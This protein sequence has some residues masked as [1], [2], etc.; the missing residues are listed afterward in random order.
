MLVIILLILQVIDT[1]LLFMLKKNGTFVNVSHKH[2]YVP[3]VKK[4]RKV[5]RPKPEYIPFSDDEDDYNDE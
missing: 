4:T 5:S 1:V 3:A 2:V